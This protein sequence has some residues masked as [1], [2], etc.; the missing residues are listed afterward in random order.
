MSSARSTC[1]STRGRSTR[2]AG[3]S[4]RSPASR[5]RSTNRSSATTPLRTRRVYQ[6]G[7]LKDKQTYEI[8]RPE[9][10]G[11]A[12]NRLV[13]GKHSGRHAFAERLRAL[14]VDF[15]DLDVGETF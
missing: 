2:R 7:V 9:T 3:C 12:S 13:L 4:P 8:M 10:V 5:C 6:D 1:A 15:E 14:G 11:L